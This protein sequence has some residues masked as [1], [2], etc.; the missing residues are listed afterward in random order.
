MDLNEVPSDHMPN[1]VTNY[2]CN[3]SEVE[4][5]CKEVE[6]K[7]VALQI[8]SKNLELEEIRGKIRVLDDERVKIEEE[9]KGLGKNL[10]NIE[11]TELIEVVARELPSNGGNVGRESDVEAKID[12]LMNEIRVLE[13][14]KNTAV[15]K[16]DEW[17]RKCKEFESRVREMEE[18]LRCQGENGD[19][20]GVKDDIKDVN[21]GG[22]SDFGSGTC[23]LGVVDG[24]IQIEGTFSME[25][26]VKR[27]LAF[28]N[29]RSCDRKIAPSTPT[30]QRPSVAVV[31]IDSDHEHD[32]SADHDISS[33]MP[34]VGVSATIGATIEEDE[35]VDEGTVVETPKRK[36]DLTVVT[37]DDEVEE[38]EVVPKRR[39][40]K[41]GDSD[42]EGEEVDDDDD[43][44]PIKRI[45]KGVT[46]DC[47]S[48]DD[49]DN[50]PI[51]QLKMN[52][53]QGSRRSAR[54]RGKNAFGQ[55][56]ANRPRRR[57]VKRGQST[58]TD[59]TQKTKNSS[60][61]L[62]KKYVEDDESEGDD[63][64]SDDSLSD[65]I[66]SDSDGEEPVDSEDREDD[67]QDDSGHSHENEEPSDDNVDFEDII[68]RLQ[69][70]KDPNSKWNLQG[71][72][73]SD[74]AK[75]PELCLRGVCA[76]HRRQIAK[77]MLW[78]DNIHN[79]GR[80]FSQFDAPRGTV[81]GEF[82]TDGNPNGDLVKTVE[83]LQAYDPEGPEICRTLAARYSNQL[84]EIY[85]NNEDPYFP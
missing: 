76:L 12:Q 67:L 34:G 29:Q 65:F 13:C 48:D 32:V 49:E 52:R 59:K 43:A 60:D 38:S 41:I 6:K 51:S 82:L 57:L 84:F 40:F 4:K 42:N 80:G 1:F 30:D 71:D 27:K 55:M 44:L 24:G 8:Q 53:A 2:N 64:R 19:F 36:R 5:R 69:R 18:R 21:V 74:F 37:S 25:N 20:S 26:Q 9:V 28:C 33:V 47:Q 61:N 39:A 85:N 22:S 75:N 50:I 17:K 35:I 23:F 45:L 14:E 54:L 46:S 83:E 78:M 62:T 10:G 16:V 56:S 15:R 7:C 3:V 77:E 72:M 79:V 70:R 58:Q 68:C 11:G 66:V 81:L 73:L 31:D 63:S